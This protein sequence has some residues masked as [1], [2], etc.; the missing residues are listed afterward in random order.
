MFGSLSYPAPEMLNE[1]QYGI[2]S[3]TRTLG[4]FIYQV[5]TGDLPFETENHCS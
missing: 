5:L 4:V 2:G 3:D 1:K